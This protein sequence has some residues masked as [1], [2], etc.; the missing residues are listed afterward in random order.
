MKKLAVLAMAGLMSVIASASNWVLALKNYG[1]EVYIDTDSIASSGVYNQIF[2]KYAFKQV[3]TTPDGRKYNETVALQEVN[4]E[5]Q[6][7][8]M[9][10]LSLKTSLNGKS[11]FSSDYNTDWSITYPD[12]AG[13]TITKLICLYRE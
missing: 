12:T 6:P 1:N 2:I 4:C 7:M 5:S 13:E 10:I 11:V 8:K 9:R 3:Q